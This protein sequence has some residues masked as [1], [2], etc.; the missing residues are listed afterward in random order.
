MPLGCFA[1]IDVGTNA[2]R[3]KVATLLRDGT[4]EPL[5]QVRDDIRPGAGVFANG[6]M[7][8]A[9][10][11]R[12]I[13]TLRG[14]HEICLSLDAQVRAVATSALRDAINQQEVVDRVATE[15]GLHLDVISGR[16]EARLIMVGLLHRHL[17]SPPTVLVDIGGGSTEVA[18]ARKHDEYLLWSARLGSMR[19][20]EVFGASG[21]VEAMKLD[22]LR[23]YIER[24]CE[25]AFAAYP[26]DAPKE[27]LGTSGS[28]RALA[29]WAAPRGG[30]SA[31]LRQVHVAVTRLAGMTLAERAKHFGLRRAEVIVVAGAI[32]EGVMRHLGSDRIVAVDAGLRDGVLVDLLYRQEHVGESRP[33]VSASLLAFG[34]RLG[35]DEV[36]ARQ[37]AHLALTLFDELEPLHQV[38]RTYRPVLHA[39]ALLHD[40]GYAVNGNRHHRHSAYLIESADLPGLTDT[41]RVVAAR[42]ARFHR[43]RPPAPGHPGLTGLSAVERRAVTRLVPLL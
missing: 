15:T 10:I 14:Y 19:L 2:A 43:R 6:E 5:H 32:L 12:L 17:A 40:V 16:E 9:A 21:K 4:I 41:E 20:T 24:A 3:L 42:L 28:I 27:T 34:R 33:D 36:H 8:E 35:F 7:S 1:A 38:P 26:N 39:A 31:S 13:A 29:A 30:G 25:D 11:E 23:R 18:L 22:L 37:V